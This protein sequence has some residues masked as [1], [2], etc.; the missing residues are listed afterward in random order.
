MFRQDRS[1]GNGGGILLAIKNCIPCRLIKSVEVGKSECIFVNVRYTRSEY[2]RCCVVY[3]PPDT[4]LEDS[5]QLYDVIYQH[6]K[7]AKMFFIVR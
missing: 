1:N 7:N 2:V 6:L 4:S 3:R 5:L